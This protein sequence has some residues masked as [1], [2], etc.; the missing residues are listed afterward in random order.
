[1]SPRPKQAAQ[2]AGHVTAP[3]GATAHAIKVNTVGDHVLLHF[4]RPCR[5]A[6]MDAETA[7]ELGADLIKHG[8]SLRRVRAAQAE[9]DV[10]K[11]AKA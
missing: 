7:V 8:S 2:Q 4:E 11:G 5:A 3:A 6:A 9:V 10:I 1:M